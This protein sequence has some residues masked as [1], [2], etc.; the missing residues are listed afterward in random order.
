MA[1]KRL[2]ADEA[3]ENARQ[4]GAGLTLDSILKD[5]EKASNE[6]YFDLEF[7]KKLDPEDEKQ[8][9]ELGYRVS[10]EGPAGATQTTISW[11]T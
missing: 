8:L 9:K 1:K 7:V 3:R 11:G 10:E 5:I 2:T 6:G 4:S